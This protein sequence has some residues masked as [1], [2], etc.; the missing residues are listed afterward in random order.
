ME[1]YDFDLQESN[2]MNQNSH[3]HGHNVKRS[4]SCCTS[5]NYRF[6]KCCCKWLNDETLFSAS[7]S[8]Q[9]T[10]GEGEVWS[11]EGCPNGYKC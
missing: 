9:F 10:E 3:N 7:L 6:G 2:N 11:C 4:P 1:K 5:F 8:K